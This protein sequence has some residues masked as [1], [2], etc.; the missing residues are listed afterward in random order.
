M[1]NRV[2]RNIF[3]LAGA[4]ALLLVGIVLAWYFVFLRP[5]QET[6]ALAQ[7][8]LST[9]VAA[10]QGQKNA[11]IAKRKAED[12]LAQL[13]GQMRFFRQRYRGLYF[14]QLGTDYASESA[15]ERANREAVW[16]NWMNTYYSGLGPSL[17]QELIAVA[18][19]TGVQIDTS[20]L[21]EA[22]PRAPEEVAPPSNGLL[23]PVSGGAAGTRSRDRAA[24][25]AS[26]PGGASAAG[27]GGSISVNITGTLPNI[28]TYFSR[29]NTTQTLMN[30]G[31]VRLET[32]S[33]V[34]T[35][36]RATFTATP[37]LLASGPGAL[38]LLN[39]DPNAAATVPAS[40]TTATTSTTTASAA[41]GGAAG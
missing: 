37:Y 15:I 2:R 36:I 3:I 7:K 17:S 20:V 5:Q 10:A 21:I 40:T 8:E 19:R 18:N 6:R 32:V 16:R 30:I 33:S 4:S 23:K 39:T 24:P 28:L 14:G 25:A 41:P 11:V 12:R 31:A 9:Q 27:T 35:R 29:L 38:P 34:P 26:A 22:P 13:N 1:E